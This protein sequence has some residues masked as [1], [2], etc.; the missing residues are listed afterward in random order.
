MSDPQSAGSVEPSIA[1]V[2]VL[3]AGAGTRMRSSLPKVLHP[4]AG[5]PLLWHALGAAAQVRPERL[6]AVIGHGREQVGSYLDD[7]HPDVL[8][9]VQ[10][11]Q[12]GTGHAVEQALAVLPG[13]GTILV[14][15]GDV[16][17]LTAA[18]LDRLAAEHHA[19]GNAVTVLTA[20]VADPSGYGRIV[21]DPSG[22]LTGIVEHRDADADQLSI[23]E[24][25]SGVYAFDG[26]VLTAA[27]AQLT[28]SNAQGERYLTDVVSMARA[29]GHRVGTVITSDATET[30]GVNDRVQLAELSRRLNARLVRA[31]QLAGVTVH[32]PART[33]LHADVRIGQDTELL[34]GTSLEAGTV[35]GS[36][37]VIGP[38]T[39]LSGCEVADG[40]SVV[41]SHCIGASIGRSATVGPF[42]FL[43]AGTALGEEA[44]V[45]A[46]VE[47]K[48]SAIGDA[49][50]VPHLSY[51][52][53]ARV[54]AGSNLGAG[55]ITANYD[56]QAKHATTIGENAFVGSDSTL[57]A[58]V[59]IGDGAYVGA[60]ST[61]TQDV[62][63]GDLAV[64]RGRQHAVT[65]WVLRR[66]NGT[67]SERSASSALSAG[68]RAGDPPGPRA[69]GEVESQVDSEV[70]GRADDTA[71]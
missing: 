36:G 43:R 2:V 7:A 50:K 47:I 45:G 5:R 8:Q 69:G 41:R 54:G 56:G 62:A 70:D 30:E 66:R 49:A 19:S 55:T 27:L 24:I 13:S 59:T 23:P 40:A 64:A 3:A 18:T 61:V 31:A 29:D 17:L 6:V 39:T 51:V 68:H 12:L 48:N 63:A 26:E 37:C 9:V 4:I 16:P 32:D 22:E 60:G 10:E 42:S 34:P 38:D 65:G 67:A 1:A 20:V 33:W 53:D 14:T 28:P 44:K 35:V 15:Y 71:G 57:V 46:F 21:R 25:N 11:A 52:G 58:P